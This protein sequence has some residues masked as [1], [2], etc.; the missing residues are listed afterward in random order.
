MFETYTKTI[1]DGA[2]E[3]KMKNFNTIYNKY[4]LDINRSLKSTW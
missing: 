4:I 2:E 1:S 3:P